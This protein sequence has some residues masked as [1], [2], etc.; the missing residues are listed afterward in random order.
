MFNNYLYSYDLPDDV[1]GEGDVKPARPLKKTKANGATKKRTSTEVSDQ[2][3][4]R[5]Y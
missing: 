5:E 3:D 4:L 2:K 1:F